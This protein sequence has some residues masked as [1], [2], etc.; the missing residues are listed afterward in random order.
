MAKRKRLTPPTLTPESEIETKSMY[1][2][3][4]APRAAP[5]IAMEA[6][7]ASGEAALDEMAETLH[8]ARA[9]GRMVISLDLDVVV[10]D[11][12]IRDRISL[13]PVDLEA[14][15]ASIAARGQQVPIEVTEL[16]D[17]RYGLISGLRRLTV[18]RMLHAAD[19]QAGFGTVLAL[20]R[21]PEESAGAYL[22]MVEENEIRAGLSYYER[23]RIAAQATAQGAFPDTGAALRGLYAA[24]SRP[25]RSKIG[26]F[27][28]VVEALDG[29]LRH[30]QQ[31]GERLGLKLA[32][33]L[34]VD[35]G[36][37]ARLTRT[38]QA[39]E[40]RTAETELAILAAAL[41]VEKKRETVSKPVSETKNPISVRRRGQ[42]LIVEGAGVDHALEAALETFLADFMAD[43]SRAKRS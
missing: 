15:Q 5:P 31:I 14:L 39:D 38:L 13:D 4:L 20:L 21:R 43:V 1:P 8:R 11:Y 7:R 22:A 23:A 16:S 18:L 27:L 10:T 12:L 17:G 36:L 40:A 41:V 19:A 42:Q 6:A 24:A 9:E 2:L 28:R 34:D 30:P 35:A 29:A 37:A 32:K 33:A 3:G 25:K 26:S